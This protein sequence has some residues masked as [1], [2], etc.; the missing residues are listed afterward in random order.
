MGLR[1]PYKQK[2]IG[3]DTAKQQSLG[4]TLYCWYLATQFSIHKVSIAIRWTKTTYTGTPNSFSMVDICNCDRHTECT[5]N[6]RIT[7]TVTSGL[8]NPMVTPVS[9]S[10]IRA[11]NSSVALINW[12]KYIHNVLL[13]FCWLWVPFHKSF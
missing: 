8:S 1:I 5:L 7:W 3:W 2:R 9:C 11:F 6:H 12:N 13:D 10:V 4:I